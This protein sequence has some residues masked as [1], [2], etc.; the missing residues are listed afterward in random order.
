[1]RSAMLGSTS[2]SDTKSICAPSRILVMGPRQTAKG[3]GSS[4][5]SL[6]AAKR[7]VDVVVDM[8]LV[9]G[10]DDGLGLRSQMP[11]GAGNQRD[12]VTAPSVCDRLEQLVD[13]LQLAEAPG[14]QSK[15][16]GVSVD[17][18]GIAVPAVVIAQPAVHRDR[19]LHGFASTGCDLWLRGETSQSAPARMRFA[20]RMSSKLTAAHLLMSVSLRLPSLLAPINHP[21]KFD[22]ASIVVQDGH[23]G[24]VK[25]ADASRDTPKL[26]ARSH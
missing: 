22:G 20:P 3:S 13:R 19:L 9:R 18:D 7:S 11:H 26:Q 4:G 17:D 5:I 21:L 25:I 2:D 10:P 14:H 1:M 16:L 12:V 23:D 24:Q 8:H 6:G 15:G